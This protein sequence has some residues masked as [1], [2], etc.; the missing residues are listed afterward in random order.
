MRILSIAE[1]KLNMMFGQEHEQTEGVFKDVYLGE[2]YSVIRNSTRLTLQQAADFC[3]CCEKFGIRILGFETGYESRYG[4]NTYAFED[5]CDEY[6]E[7]WWLSA[8]SDL[9]RNKITDSII[10]FIDIPETV[11]NDYI[12]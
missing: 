2:W 3:T 8:L 10:P 9:A 6:T 7:E 11:L 5:Y 12:N 1:K 4:L